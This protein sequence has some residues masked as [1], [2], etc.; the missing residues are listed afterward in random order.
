MTITADQVFLPLDN[1]DVDQRPGSSDVAWA[2]RAYHHEQREATN[3]RRRASRA[4]RRRSRTLLMALAALFLTTGLVFVMRYQGSAPASV[5]HPATSSQTVIA[6]PTTIARS[7]FTLTPP[8]IS[9]FLPLSSTI[10][11]PMR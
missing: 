9:P 4:G 2:E 3:E 10:N 6:P 8:M 11:A 7:P 5:T 1:P